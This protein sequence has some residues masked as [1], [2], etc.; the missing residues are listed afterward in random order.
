MAW[1]PVSEPGILWL[2]SILLVLASIA[3]QLA[4][5]TDDRIDF[6]GR[7]RYFNAAGLLTMAFLLGQLY[8]WNL[9]YRTGEYGVESPAFSFFILLTAV[10]G[11][12]LLGGL[13]VWTRTASR[14]KSGLDKADLIEIGAIRQSMQ[15]CAT[16]WHFL[17]LI[18][19]VLFTILLS[20]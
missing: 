11:L 4:A 16:Y 15:L 14:L 6:A 9:L 5:G 12:H 1:V 19:I 8:G 2:N 13:V 7:R 3:F 20:T 17:L 10:H 18:W